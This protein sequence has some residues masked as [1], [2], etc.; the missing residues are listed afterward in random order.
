MTLIE[1]VRKLKGYYEVQLI[2]KRK[3]RLR[4]DSQVEVIEDVVNKLKEILEDVDE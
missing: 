4:L 2:T 1:E 3:D